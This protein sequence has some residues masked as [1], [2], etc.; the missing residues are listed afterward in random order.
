MCTNFLKKY[1]FPTTP[2]EAYLTIE[3]FF[4]SLPTDLP[5]LCLT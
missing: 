5:T 3:Q 2:R 1:N 4:K